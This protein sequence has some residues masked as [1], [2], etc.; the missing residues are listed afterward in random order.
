MR[1]T[2][3]RL[4]KLAEEILSD[5]EKET[6]DFRPNFDDSL[7]EPTVLPCKV[8]NLLINGSSGI[9]VGMATNMAPHNLTEAIEAT[10]AYIDNRDIDIPALMKFVKAPDFPTGGI[11][12]GT[13]GVRQAYE[14]GRGRVVIRSKSN[15]EID[16]KGREKIVITEIPYQ[17]NK[18]ELIRKSAELVNEKIIEGISDIRDE[19]DRE[20]MRIVFDLK[21]DAVANVVLNKLFKYTEL[22]SSFS[23]NN[24]ALVKGRPMLLNLKDL[25]SNFVEHRHEVITRRTQ[26]ELRKAEE[27]AHILQGYLIALDHLDEVIKVIRESAT[28]NDA[29]S[30][31]ISRFGLSEIQAKAILEMRLRALTGLERDK[32]KQEYEELMQLI[33]RLKDILANEGL[34]MEIIKTELVEMKEKYGDERRT[35]IELVAGEFNV[36]DMI[37]DEAMVITISHM[38]Y[39]KRTPLTEFRTQ[40][41][42]GVGSKGSSAREDDFLEHLFVATN[43]NYLLFFTKKGKCYWLRV[44]EVPEG[45]KGSKGRAIQN[46]INIEPD[47]KVM[48]YI[49]VTSL[50]D[51]EY[52]NNNFIIM[53]TNKGTI[54]KT[55]LEAFSRPRANG[56]A[57]ITINDGEQL[58]E[59]KLTSGK[60]EIMMALRS[61]QCIRFNESTVRPM[62]RNAA[63]VKGVTLQSANDEVIGLIA[64]NDPAKT[65]LVVSEKGYG[66]R[67]DIEDYRVTNRGGKGVRTIAVTEK[68]GDLIA[69]KE[70]NES[71][72]LMIINKSGITLRIRVSTLR[73]MGRAT[74]GVRI[75]NLRDEDEIAAVAKIDMSLII[76]DEN[77]EIQDTI[78]EDN[79]DLNQ[80][81]ETNE[82][83][84]EPPVS[85]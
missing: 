83:T 43:H 45:N 56:I 61:G 24:I 44:F 55:T 73:V 67:S 54:K 60:D 26:F 35:Q 20:G 71:D 84:D 51:E 77:P 8:P 52:I 68:T 32:I 23:I 16:E 15:I 41:R 66:K 39:I 46:L 36:E 31:L 81:N 7:V 4:K 78:S 85:E 49:N 34:R 69:I 59:A 13:E 9:A 50:S 33:A 65:I 18:A 27:R 17:I 47:D 57:A 58:L 63:G 21:R 12:Y 29:Q 76:E 37:A 62:G 3:A 38:G 75:I 5:I 80:A 74:Q 64:V 6:V 79:S 30:E 82:N 28:P 42:G 10:I 48:A 2:E 1:Y 19:S 53:C 22:Q 40:G 11:I 14:T 72:D 70:V 25:I